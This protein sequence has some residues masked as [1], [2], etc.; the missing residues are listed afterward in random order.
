MG[1]LVTDSLPGVLAQGIYRLTE[2]LSHCRRVL[3]SARP[4]TGQTLRR[5]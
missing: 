2:M 5:T 1:E 4:G 3:Q